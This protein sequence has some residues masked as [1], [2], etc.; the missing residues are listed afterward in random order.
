MQLCVSTVPATYFAGF[1]CATRLQEVDWSFKDG[2]SCKNWDRIIGDRTKP[3]DQPPK[4]KYTT[5]IYQIVSC[6]KQLEAQMVAS[7]RRYLSINWLVSFGDPQFVWFNCLCLV[8]NAP[9]L[10]GAPTDPRSS[11]LGVWGMSGP[12]NKTSARAYLLLFRKG[13][14]KMLEG[15]LNVITILSA[16]CWK[17]ILA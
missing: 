12:A 17:G 6:Y 11:K 1:A 10:V 15:L 4:N 13:G 14:W 8:V 9:Q 2:T 16:R 5:K 3:N 7:C